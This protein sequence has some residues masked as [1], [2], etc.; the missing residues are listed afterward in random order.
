MA[1]AARRFGKGVA[2][3]AL[4]ALCLSARQS[5]ADDLKVRLAV[6]RG[7]DVRGCPDAPALAEEVT[8]S[9]GH[10]AIDVTPDA[11]ARLRLEV[12]LTRTDTGYHATIRIMGA[13]IGVRE[14]EHTGKTCE[15]LAKALVVSLAVLID[16]VE[17][18]VQDDAPPPEEPEKPPEPPK[19]PPQPDG[20]SLAI[21]R[22]AT[23]RLPDP[24][25]I[26]APIS[27]TAFNSLFVELAGPGLAYSINYERILGATNL[28]VRL[29]FGYIHVSG[30]VYGL[31]DVGADQD[32]L[33]VPL[34]VSYYF[35]TP[36]HKVQLG[37]GA[38]YRR[39]EEDENG[40]ASTYVLGTA[41]VGYR[42]LPEDGG[43]NLG[44]AFTP[45]LGPDKKFTPWFGVTIGLGY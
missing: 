5:R 17:Q 9:R 43:I 16:D 11:E 32:D 31:L 6:A 23:G 15:P 21:R 38:V 33:S 30:K 40:G 4:A 34:V 20:P 44:V 37:L 24:P 39:R 27:R 42:Y 8:R 25:E 29:G 12:G 26:P 1:R 3:A 2:A 22:S 19:P 41:V 13:R 45:M 10:G 28:S 14:I 36:S 7:P 35:G 18:G